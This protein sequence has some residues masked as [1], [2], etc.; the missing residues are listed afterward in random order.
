MLYCDV[1]EWMLCEQFSDC[2]THDD[3]SRCLNV[4]QTVRS[5]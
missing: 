1:H 2:S 3:F 5:L 4:V